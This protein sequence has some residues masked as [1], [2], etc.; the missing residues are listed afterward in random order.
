VVTTDA[1]EFSSSEGGSNL[2]PILGGAIGAA[3]LLGAV[4]AGLA[5]Y[6]RKTPKKAESF[7]KRMSRI[8]GNVTD[9]PF[10]K[11]QTKEGMNAIYE[12][13]HN[14]ELVNTGAQ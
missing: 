8:F 9:N 5:V 12:P 3:A 11:A 14:L 1:G 4:T 7:K 13:G 6:F 10:Y 2:G